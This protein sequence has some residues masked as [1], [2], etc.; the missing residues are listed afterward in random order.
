MEASQYNGLILR[1]RGYRN[2]KT[3]IA[4]LSELRQDV[5]LKLSLDDINAMRHNPEAY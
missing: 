3:V 1:M 2:L 5:W 4:D